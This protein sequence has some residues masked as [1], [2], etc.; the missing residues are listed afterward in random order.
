MM[1]LLLFVLFLLAGVNASAQ[2]YIK[3]RVTDGKNE[4]PLKGASVYINNTTI[5]TVTDDNGEFSLGPFAAG[6]YEVIASYVGYAP[7]L[8]TAELKTAGYRITFKLEPKEKRLREILILTDETRRKYLELFKKN[9]LGFTD[10]AV[11]CRIRN[12]DEVQFTPGD[13]K[14][15]FLAYADMELV[16][17][18]PDLGYVIR[19]ELLDFYY[20]LANGSTY[21][22]GYTRY[23]EMSKDGEIKKRYLRKR[24]QVYEGSTM[25]FFRSLVKKDLSRQG[26]E[27]LQIIQVPKKA[28]DSIVQSGT[29]RISGSGISGMQMATKVNEEQM[30]QLYSDSGYLLYNLKIGDGWRVTYNKTT[31][32][33]QDLQQKNLLMGQTPG[34]ST[35]GLRLRDKKSEQPV[36]VNERGL[37]LTPMLLYYDFMWGYERLA[38]ML[39][40]DYDPDK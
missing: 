31:S 30:I 40:E 26:F 28:A 7:L 24:K 11:R 25:H 2:L 18:N 12:I 35:S 1:K 36:L 3:G 19:F 29:F 17:D 39:P 20:N 34:S 9:V 21:F 16:I 13:T 37:L 8:F 22:F 14:N 33:K 32:L 23:E 6:N 15:E 10:G 5:G 27:V 4:L 38:N